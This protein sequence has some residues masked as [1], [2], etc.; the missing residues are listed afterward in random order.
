MQ[1]PGG[2]PYTRPHHLCFEFHS[3]DITDPPVTRLSI[4]SATIKVSAIMSY[5]DVDECCYGIKCRVTLRHNCP[6]HEIEGFRIT[7]LMPD[8]QVHGHALFH[9][10][11]F[12]ERA[13]GVVFAHLYNV[14]LLWLEM[15]LQQAS[16]APRIVKPRN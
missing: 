13:M 5:L 9:E 15:H 10:S 8:A 2:K 3:R 14:N 16:E 12:N 4:T 7:A 11:L 6:C 1:L